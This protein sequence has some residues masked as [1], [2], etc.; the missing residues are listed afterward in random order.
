MDLG[1][2][3]I[4]SVLDGSALP[5]EPHFRGTTDEQWAAHR[6]IFDED[7]K[8]HSVGGYLVRGR[9][10]T[11][12]VDAGIGQGTLLGIACGA[13]L[14]NLGALGVTPSDITDVIFTHLHIDHL[15]WAVTDERPVSRTR[16]FLLPADWDHFM[17]D[18]QDHVAAHLRAPSATA[19]RPAGWATILPGLDAIAAPGHTPGSTV[20]VASSGTDRAMMLGDVVHCPVSRSTTSGA[21]C[22]TST[23]ARERTRTPWRAGWKARPGDGRR[24]LPGHAV[25]PPA[26]GEGKRQWVV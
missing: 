21:R 3:R 22:S 12:L 26:R 7:G 14:E 9:A 15:G 8:L 25:R 19:S 23:P 24:P 17:A 11:V 16:P 18:H 1:D 4:D 2:L 13:M 5:P 6:D 10:R 20:V